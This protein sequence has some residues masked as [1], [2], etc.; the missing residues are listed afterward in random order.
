[1][2]SIVAILA[3]ISCFVGVNLQSTNPISGNPNFAVNANLFSQLL[4]TFGNSSDTILATVQAVLGD[5]ISGTTGTLNNS[6]NTVKD[7]L[8]AAGD[9]AV[10]LLSKLIQIV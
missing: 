5:L 1:M 8:L 6:S 10:T 3:I 9:Q 7:I 2:R 4:S